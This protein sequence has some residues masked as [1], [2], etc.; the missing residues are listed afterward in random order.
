M[1][2]SDVLLIAALVGFVVIWWV[3]ASAKRDA[4]LLILALAK[5]P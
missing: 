2:V 5:L 3:K 4:A 1:I